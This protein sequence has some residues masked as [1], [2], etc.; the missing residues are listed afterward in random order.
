MADQQPKAK[1]LDTPD[2][3]PIRQNSFKPLELACAT[4]SEW[5][6]LPVDIRNSQ[7]R[8]FERGCI[9]EVMRRCD[10]AGIFCNFNQPAFL[11]DYSQTIYKLA[12]NLENG[13]LFAKIITN[14][15]RALDAAGMSSA[16]MNPA[17][18]AA[19]RAENA[20]RAN[21][22]IIPRTSTAYKCGKCGKYNTLQ[23][24]Y[25]SRC[26]DEGSTISMKCQECGHS[27]R[28]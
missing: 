23:E 10:A 19:E 21:Q 7:I 27:W 3:C 28:M 4:H 24:E 13:P 15:I 25:Q 26:A 8:R 18:Y 22:V 9:H 1:L 6:S 16:D 17:R 14:Q 5:H 20:I 2:N 12:Y 11:A